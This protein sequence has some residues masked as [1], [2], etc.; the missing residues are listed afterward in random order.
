MAD[1]DGDGDP[2][3]VLTSLSDLWDVDFSLP[4][5]ANQESR[6]QLGGEPQAEVDDRVVGP[7]WRSFTT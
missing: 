4:H 1:F 5:R 6:D 3:V 7:T 2:D